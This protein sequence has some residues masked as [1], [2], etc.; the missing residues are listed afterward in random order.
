MGEHAAYWR[1]LMEQG[2]AV[3]FGPVGG[4]QGRMGARG[5]ARTERG[6]DARDE[7]RGSRDPVEEGVQ[8]QDLA[9][10]AGGREGVSLGGTSPLETV[11]AV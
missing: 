3:V 9:D 11:D 1:G 2:A 8:L 10:G 4:P 6:G 5:R 7:G